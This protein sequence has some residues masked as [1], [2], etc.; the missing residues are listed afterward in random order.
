MPLTALP[1]THPLP[2]LARIVAQLPTS[3]AKIAARRRVSNAVGSESLAQQCPLAGFLRDNITF[4]RKE[5]VSYSERRRLELEAE[6]RQAV[7]AAPSLGA[8]QQSAGGTPGSPAG[9]GAAADEQSVKDL[10]KLLPG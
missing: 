4:T 5:F 3:S 1:T 2:P 6:D 9:A 8:Q 7:E 10:L